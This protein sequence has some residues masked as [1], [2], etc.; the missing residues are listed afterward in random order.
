MANTS[1]PTV[2]AA[3]ARSSSYKFLRQIGRLV[4]PY[5]SSEQKWRVRGYTFALFLLTLA[6]VALAVWTSYWNRAL[7]DALEARSLRQFLWQIGA[8]AII[9]ALTI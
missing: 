9:F 4:G 8:F 5:W 6:Q 3:E 1:I 7:F 2:P